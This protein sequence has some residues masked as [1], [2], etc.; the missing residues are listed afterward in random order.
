MDANKPSEPKGF[1]K[2]ISGKNPAQGTINQINVDIN[3]LSRRIR[4]ME[5]RYYNLRKKT[6]L[7]DQNMLD[8][9]KRINNQLKYFTSNIKEL[10]KK[11]TD[12]SEKLSMFD[13]ELKDTAKKRDLTIIDKYLEFWEP[14]NFLTE[15]DARQI[16]KDFL[17]EIGLK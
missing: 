9:N 5:E 15:K 16:I 2:K 14:M 7:T 4:M 11:V 12:I 17:D 13:E 10:K 6:Q 3:T 1:D 8:D